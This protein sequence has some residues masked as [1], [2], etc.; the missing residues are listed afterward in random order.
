MQV[1]AGGMSGDSSG[2]RALPAVLAVLGILAIIAGILYVSGAANSVHLMVGSV[3]HGHHQVRAAVSFVVGVA[4][5]VGAWL[6]AR[7]GSRRT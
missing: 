1:H 2:R 4:L 6:A 5:L 7:P 3:H